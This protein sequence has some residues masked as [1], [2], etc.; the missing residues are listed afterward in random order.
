MI[1]KSIFLKIKSSFTDL[2]PIILVIAFFQIVVLKQPLPQMGEVLFGAI[3][4]VTGLIL[5]IQGDR[6]SVV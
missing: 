5:F 2:L 6:K 1:I 4:V 3:L